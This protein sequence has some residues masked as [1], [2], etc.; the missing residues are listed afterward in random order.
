M[1]ET[2]ALWASFIPFMAIMNRIRGGGFGAEKLPLHPRY[3]VTAALFGM[4]L[5]IT[6]PLFALKVS[7]SY[8]MWCLPP[9]GRWYTMDWVPMQQGPMDR[10]PSWFEKAIE[11]VTVSQMEAFALRQI[12]GFVP[13]AILLTPWA[14]LA[15]ILTV[16]IYETSWWLAPKNREIEA[17]ELGSGVIWGALILWAL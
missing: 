11:A 4:F 12:I 14:L 5:A 1:S 7:V 13:A 8:L 16:G 10:P 17:A 3:Y 2:L 6:G 15:A 9:W